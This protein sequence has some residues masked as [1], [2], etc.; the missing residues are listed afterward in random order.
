MLDPLFVNLNY[1]RVGA[2]EESGIR[3]APMN[4]NGR[5]YSKKKFKKRLACWFVRNVVVE[6]V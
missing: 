2:S 4:I 3:D 5:L 1:Y 6:R